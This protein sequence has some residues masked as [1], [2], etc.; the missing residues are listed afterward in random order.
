MRVH[1]P[2]QLRSGP[3]MLAYKIFLTVLAVLFLVVPAYLLYSNV[4]DASGAKDLPE[5]STQL[6]APINEYYGKPTEVSPPDPHKHPSDI[7][8]TFEMLSIDP[9]SSFAN[10]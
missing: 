9:S 3:A 5:K 6:A 10:L 2:D 8:V 1:V 7:C 4:V